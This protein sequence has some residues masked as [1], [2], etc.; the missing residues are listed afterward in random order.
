MWTWRRWS[1]I[2]AVHVAPG[3][4]RI[5]YAIGHI[6]KLF[7]FIILNKN[8][9][10]RIF[11]SSDKLWW[12]QLMHCV[13]IW[14]QYHFA[15]E[16][17]AK[18]TALHQIVVVFKW[19]GQWIHEFYVWIRAPIGL[20]YASLTF[21]WINT[22]FIWTV[23]TVCHNNNGERFLVWILEQTNN[24]KN[25]NWSEFRYF[26]DAPFHIVSKA[27]KMS[28]EINRSKFLLYDWFIFGLIIICHCPLCVSKCVAKWVCTLHCTHDSQFQL[29]QN[30][31]GWLAL[32]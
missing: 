1:C 22:S 20:E 17:R 30:N 14:P 4:W 32:I 3:N 23:E 8:S 2:F 13:V 7:L 18:Q 26:D 21:H 15:L 24:A 28:Y 5:K 19:N 16:L 12:H 6:V 10:R 11:L 25:K 9:R 31:I 29:A 27:S